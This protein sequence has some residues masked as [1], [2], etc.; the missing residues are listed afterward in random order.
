M[1]FSLILTVLFL[2]VFALGSGCASPEDTIKSEPACGGACVNEPEI[3]SADSNPQNKETTE[4]S[5]VVDE[6]KTG[7]RETGEIVDDLNNLFHS[8][9]DSRPKKTPDDRDEAGDQDGS[10]D[11]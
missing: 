9:N 8:M 4:M 6:L 5:E 2:C 3:D 1:P 10:K 7:L 11:G